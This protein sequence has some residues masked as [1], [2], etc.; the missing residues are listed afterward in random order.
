[1]K[2][3]RQIKVKNRMLFTSFSSPFKRPS[4]GRGLLLHILKTLGPNPFN[5]AGSSWPSNA[6]SNGRIHPAA[7]GPKQIQSGQRRLN[8]AL[9]LHPL[10]FSS[11]LPNLSV[12]VK[13]GMHSAPPRILERGLRNGVMAKRE[14]AI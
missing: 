10:L 14:K 11:I 8:E 6:L 13:N 12:F 7:A 4:H 3:N 9:N 1:M 2:L 5:S